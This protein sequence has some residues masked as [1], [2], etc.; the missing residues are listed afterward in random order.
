MVRHDSPQWQKDE[1]FIRAE[2]LH[3]SSN[4]DRPPWCK[5]YSN[6]TVG[7][8][9]VENGGIIGAAGFEIVDNYFTMT[10]WSLLT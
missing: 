8:L 5:D 6:D 3:V 9:M 2:A 10:E 7:I 1:V 4:H